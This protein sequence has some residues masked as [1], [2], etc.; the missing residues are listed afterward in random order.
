VLIRKNGPKTSRKFCET[1]TL[2]VNDLEKHFSHVNAK[3]YQTRYEI[4]LY[5]NKLKKLLRILM[6]KKNNNVEGSDV[7]SPNIGFPLNWSKPDH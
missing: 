1:V 2:K 4:K 3:Y 6:K 5:D 7:K